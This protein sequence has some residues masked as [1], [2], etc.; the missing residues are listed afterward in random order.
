MTAIAMGTS[1]DGGNMTVIP[2][3]SRS[4]G[5]QLLIPDDLLQVVVHETNCFAQQYIKTTLFYI[6]L[7]STCKHSFGKTA[8]GVGMV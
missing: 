3:Y 8:Q 6:L 1:M 4:P 7:T 5:R 2:S